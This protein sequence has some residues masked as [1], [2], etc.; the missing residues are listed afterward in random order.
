VGKLA[1]ID[2]LTEAFQM[3]Y[4][5]SKTP[6]EWG[7]A[8]S[9]PIYKN[10]GVK[11]RCENNRGISLFNHA[12]KLYENI[13]EK[14]LRNIVEL[15]LGPWQHGFRKERIVYIVYRSDHQGSG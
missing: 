2:T 7:K 6:D 15:K 11:I 5:E 14:R 4:K 10:K 13:L 9:C 3:A 12:A 1:T 8:I